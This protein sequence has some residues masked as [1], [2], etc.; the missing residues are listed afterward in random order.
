MEY[1]ILVAEDEPNTAEILRLILTAKGYRVVVAPDGAA[2]LE[3]A[4]RLEPD[5]VMLDVRMPRL[6]GDAVT[7]ALKDDPR[8]ARVPVVLFSSVDEVDI[9]WRDA[10]AD[11]FLQKPF[12]V[13]GLPGL[14]DDLLHGRKGPPPRRGYWAA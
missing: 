10:G 4:R 12:D 14:V 6:P 5:L 9:R 13:A 2:A 11:V 8:L 1:T 7:K 3:T